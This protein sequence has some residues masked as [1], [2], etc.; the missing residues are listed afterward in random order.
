MSS[1]ERLVQKLR[2]Y[3]ERVR[4]LEKRVET[5]EDNE[6]GW[7]ELQKEHGIACANVVDLQ[8]EVEQAEAE[9]ETLQQKYEDAKDQLRE[10]EYEREDA[11]YDTDKTA[12]KLRERI[13]E[14]EAL[15]SDAESRHREDRSNYDA[16]LKRVRDGWDQCQEGCGDKRLRLADQE[17]ALKEAS[18]VIG[19]LREQ[20]K[21]FDQREV[22]RLPTYRRGKLLRDFCSAPLSHVD[23]GKTEYHVK[24]LATTFVIELGAT[25]CA[26]PANGMALHSFTK[27][28]QLVSALV[29]SLNRGIMLQYY[30][31]RRWRDCFLAGAAAEG[32]IEHV[33]VRRVLNYEHESGDGQL[34][35]SVA[36]LRFADFVDEETFFAQFAK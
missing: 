31:G 23:A 2:H 1:E 27:R 26:T 9:I 24:D 33:R 4:E 30:H 3:K 13:T 25:D 20:V 21:V 16:T 34:D 6:Q 32:G 19:E 17:D 11:R 12:G 36:L 18:A 14:L 5:L 28:S 10:M 8:F 29:Y 22:A 7:G 35:V 15:L